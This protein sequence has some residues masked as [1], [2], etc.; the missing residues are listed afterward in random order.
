M[1][2]EIIS[3]F[4]DAMIERGIEPHDA[5]DIVP[6]DDWH[7]MSQAGDKPGKKVIY[8]RL[9]I[10]DGFAVGNFGSRREG[11]TH[12]WTSKASRKLSDDER[13]AFKKRIA[14]QKK[15]READRERR[16]EEV[17][18]KC[19]K[20]W[21]DADLPMER[22]PYLKA[23]GVECEAL[24]VEGDNLLVPMYDAA[25]KLWGLQTISPDGDK[26]FP[27]GGRKQGCFY[28]LPGT[29]DTIYIC[30][31]LSTGLSIHTA[32]NTAMVA[33]AF[34]AG[35]LVPV[36][37]ALR[38]K[39]PDAKLVIACDNDAYTES[40]NVGI[41][42]GRQAAAKVE[43]FAIWPEFASN[44]A[45]K[46]TDFNDLHKEQGIEAVRNQ[47]LSKLSAS[48]EVAAGE[49]DGGGFLE[50]DSDDVQPP[51]DGDI[52][53]Y[54]TESL[55]DLGLP[56]RVLGYNREKYYYFPFDKCQ[57]V[58]LTAAG[59]TLNNLMQLATLEQWETALGG[60]GPQKLSS[61]Q[62]STYATN[63]LF[64]I[65]HRRG[66]FREE[67]KV[68]GCGAWMD[69]GRR[70]LH[71]GDTIY[72]DGVPAE[73]KDVISN[74]VYI[75]SPKLLTP[76]NTPLS[77][78]QAHKLRLICEMPT[79]E[80]P[81]SGSLLAGWL[82]IAPVCSILTWRPHIWITGEAEAGK[83]TIMERIIKPVL[84]PIA[85]QVD[86]GTTEASIRQRMGYDGRPMVYDEAE[87]ESQHD[88]TIMD[89]VIGLAR[90]ASS[91]A[92][93]SKHG[94]DPFKAQ[95]CACF[96]SINPNVRMYADESRISMFSL[97]KN[98]SDSA[99]ADYDDLLNAISDTL[100]P[101]FQKNLLART[102]ANMPVLIENVEV[103]KR[104]ART[105]LNAARV[106]D[107]ISP[108]LAGLYLLGSNKVI[109]AA[110]AEDW[111]L[112]QDWTMNT[113]VDTEPDSVRLVRHLASSILRVTSKHEGSMEYSV[114]ELVQA[115]IRHSETINKEF[116][117]ANLRRHG[118]AAKEDGVD[119]SKR[120]QNLAKLL[121]GTQW[122]V[123]WHRVLSDL[124]GAEQRDKTYFTPG[125]SQRAIRIPP[126]YFSSEQDQ[127]AFAV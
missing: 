56:L 127:H 94:Q 24:R 31:G 1:T 42:K 21:H 72:I 6:D 93:I 71:C 13:K 84:G 77:A 116:A 126:S 65:A 52:V 15:Q 121:R 46:Y 74:Y 41:D 20:R 81:L 29:T 73:P 112:N 101:E 5:S 64:R 108:M 89:G 125:D 117:D 28:P 3:Q 66:V 10:D 91:G 43:G 7:N 97:K 40:G 76:S 57:I 92:T 115:C 4:A 23:K 118:I 123:N 82:V 60:G 96:S 105:V 87:S 18:V 111:I 80:T 39:Y 62:I 69:A 35:N 47:I 9:K 54:E 124:P 99:Q 8:Y 19:S 55:G 119:I 106:A 27:A 113:A 78:S 22:H 45:N 102:I 85:L 37:E 104:A 51:P 38:A 79:W 11:V 58:E 86:G 49:A 2:E 114:G 48:A 61:N 30:E 53:P 88:R 68:R 36:A 17:S 83:S 75:A 109:G 34:D 25:G 95:F 44:G 100:T 90:K 120:N 14:E 63:A 16:A 122:E 12:T 67:N 110:E 33:C 103:F 50:P 26:F 32:L 70:M 98:R 107:Q 59:H